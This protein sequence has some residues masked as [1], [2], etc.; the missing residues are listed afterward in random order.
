MDDDFEIYFNNRQRRERQTNLRRPRRPKRSQAEI[1]AE[2]VEYG[3]LA[4]VGAEAVFNPSLNASRH[5]RD[6]ILNYLGPFYDDEHITDV[7]RKVKGGK[8]AT[9]YCCAAHPGTGLELIAAKVYRPRMFRNLRNDARYRQGRQILDEQ[10]KAVLDHCQLR[11]VRKG[12][13]IGK[14]LHHTSWLE[15]EFQTMQLLYAAGADIP[16]P[17]AH[18]SNV[19]LM[20]YV[21]EAAVPALTL[22]QVT[23]APD[24]VQSL[25]ERL[26]HNVELMLAC[27]R[28]HGDLSAYN[29]LY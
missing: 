26:L 5:E 10:G 2:V 4:Q 11:A 27:Q 1:L 24:E 13:K 12:T 29:V 8:E 7:L 18:G 21:G 9:V 25:F 19:I 20:E 16:Q 6:W 3:S 17:L 23:L 14:D 15:H 28:V 22:N